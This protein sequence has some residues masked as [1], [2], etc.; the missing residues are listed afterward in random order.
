[1]IRTKPNSP[2][3]FEANEEG[4]VKLFNEFDRYHLRSQREKTATPDE[5]TVFRLAELTPEGDYFNANFQLITALV[6]MPHLDTEKEIEKRIGRPLTEVEK[7][8]LEQRIESAKVW[9]ERYA[10]EEEKTRLQETLPAR[11]NELNAAQRGFLQGLAT[12]SPETPWE[13]EQLQ[14]KIFEIARMTPIDQP[15][16]FKAIYRVL[17]D[18]EAGPKAGN[19]LAFLD[20]D[21][22]ITRFQELPLEREDFFRE[23]SI[24]VEDLEKFLTK[25]KEKIVS[26][27]YATATEGS[28]AVLEV[29]VLLRDGKRML[30]RV[31]LEGEVEQAMPGL[32]ARLTPQLPGLTA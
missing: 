24:S 3:N 31:R 21:F 19:L 5:A 6:Q 20:R 12:V 11:A 22:V 10:S 16:A 25:E 2:V 15:V 32:V 7:R 23:T 14:A 26:A 17:L 8:H 4:I 27:N 18:R 13:D 9:V 30:K 1:M 28:L 29:T